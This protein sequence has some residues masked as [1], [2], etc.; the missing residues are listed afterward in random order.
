MGIGVFNAITDNTYATIKDSAGN[1]RKVLTEP[2]TN[3]NVLV[4][5]QQLK[6]N[7]NFYIINTNVIRDKHYDD[8]NVT[9]SGFTISL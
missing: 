7:S 1:S 9:G 3:F 8:A 2:F 6:N 4:V 5:D